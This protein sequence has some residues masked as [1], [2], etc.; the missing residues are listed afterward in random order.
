MKIVGFAAC[1]EGQSK[2]V[3]KTEPIVERVLSVW[4]DLCQKIESER[5]SSTID[6][7]ACLDR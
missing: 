4:R 5:S 2:T 7:R 6:E 3:C 1:L